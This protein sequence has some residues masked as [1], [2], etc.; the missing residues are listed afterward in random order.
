M[1][2]VAAAVAKRPMRSMRSMRHVKNRR[3]QAGIG[4]LTMSMESGNYFYRAD[5]TPRKR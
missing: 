5:A 1:N 4:H 3:S 2:V